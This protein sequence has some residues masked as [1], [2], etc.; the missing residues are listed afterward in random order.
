MLHGSIISL[1]VENSVFFKILLFLLHLL[2][3]ILLLLRPIFIKDV[4]THNIWHR[5]DK[6]YTFS[7]FIHFQNNKLLP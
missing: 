5:K 7:L 4:V 6:I 2:V 3:G 1:E